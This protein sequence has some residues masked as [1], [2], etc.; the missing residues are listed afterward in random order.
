M[1]ENS[2]SATI[3]DV[4]QVQA[5]SQEH[6]PK[7]KASGET[8]PFVDV[9][10]KKECID[11]EVEAKLRA[12][13]AR[14]KAEHADTESN[15]DDDDQAT[16]SEGDRDG[17]PS[18]SSSAEVDDKKAI[19]PVKS[20][21]EI[22]AEL[23]SVF[24][25]APPEELLD[26]KNLLNKKHKKVKK[27]K[28]EKREKKKKTKKIDKSD[29]ECSESDAV[30]A[31]GGKHRH[32]HK[33]K[34]KHK[35]NKER[36]K[37]KEGAGRT[38]GGES[39]AKGHERKRHVTEST[40]V[41][42]KKICKTEQSVDREQEWGK[43]RERDREKERA[44]NSFY[45]GFRDKDRERERGHSREERE[46]NKTDKIKSEQRH[47]EHASDV[48]LSDEETYL[49][50]RTNGRR[51]PHNS[52][53]DDTSFTR[54]KE[55]PRGEAGS[56]SHRRRS[57]SHNRARSRSRS[58]DLGID[59]KRLLEIAR[60]NAIMMF[61]RGTIPGVEDM[62]QE[63]KDK[64]LL[65]MR[66][67]GRTVQDLTDF[68]KKIS[69]GEVLSDLS[70]EEDSDVDKNGNAKAFHHPF[71][72]KEREPIVMHIRNST[73]IVPVMR[74][75]EQIKA[76]T[77]QFPVSS[78][79]NHRA[80]EAWVP[81]DRKETLAPLPTLPPAKQ[82]T[83]IF[84]DVQ[85]NV[86]AKAIPQLE[87]QEPAFKSVGSQLEIATTL[88]TNGLPPTPVPPPIS[89]PS[90][91]PLVPTAITS[92]AVTG[93]PFVPE[94]PIPSTIN[95][96]PPVLQ[97]V[98]HPAPPTESIFPQTAP[99]NMDV[100]S[101]ITQRLSAIRRLQENPT[102]FEAMKMMYN[103]QRNMCSWASSK[104]VPG[105]FTGSTGAPVMKA[106]ELNSGPQL[107]A[108][109]DQLTST[110]PVTGGMGMA[111]LK[112]MGWK[113]GEGLGRTKTGSL[114]PLLLHVK[115]DKRGLVSSED[116]NYQ[117]PRTNVTQRKKQPSGSAGPVALNTQD[118]H[119]VCVLNELTSKNRWTAPQ[120]TLQNDTGPPHSRMFL[121]SVEVNGQSYMP[122]QASSTKKEAKLNAAKLCLQALGI[123]PANT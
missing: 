32:K 94:V 7:N 119:P 3:V 12:I 98:P 40:S 19:A 73:P 115:L 52:F 74:R 47:S 69:N 28:K 18:A 1:T 79:Q 9:K 5:K 64:V 48:S 109:R 122:A 60:K 16:E 27:E 100:S 35:H 104:H 112:K 39:V 82:A 106:H 20:S 8:V 75:E 55:E 31:A 61:K 15:D 92:A 23:F 86:F 113:P 89:T 121:F 22:L 56:R 24:N 33:H 120:Y 37:S 45:N 97:P 67:G 117:A 51:R 70:S 43:E 36:E 101:I 102:D 53:Y 103:A 83:N 66:Y 85:K 2:D 6:Q 118:K 54:I 105:Q 77:M 65:K 116:V 96:P 99:P 90:V 95:A 57:R 46:H 110:K 42:A 4:S 59:K 17:S 11:A 76:I 50:E 49:R 10:V 71:K 21:N 84:K 80:S 111:L 34:R 38:D 29:G 72:L 58:R 87:Q 14:I 123:L 114:Q 26:D 88:E 78:G 25:A 81:V 91:E 108:R 30:A 107:W 63:I 93:R 41:P 13:N 62:T 68:C 44:H